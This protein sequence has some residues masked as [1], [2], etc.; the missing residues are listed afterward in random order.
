MDQ[1]VEDGGSDPKIAI[2]MG[3]VR[4]KPDCLT[5]IEGTPRSVNQYLHHT[6]DDDD[7]FGH[8]GFMGF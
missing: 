4:C 5:L 8:P 7:M 3:T 6:A 1:I 2:A